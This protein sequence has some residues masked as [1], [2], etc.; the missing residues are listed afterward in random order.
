SSESDVSMPTSPVHDRYQSGEG[1]HAVPPPYIGTF[2]PPKLDLVFHDASTVSETI[3][4]VINVEPN[5]T[6]P[7]KKMSQSN[8]PS[9]PIIED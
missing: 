4:T 9:A 7:T 3:F 8:R 2:M 6:K 5:T 1:Y